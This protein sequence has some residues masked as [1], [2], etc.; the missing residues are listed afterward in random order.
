MDEI[1]QEAHLHFKNL[2]TE[3]KEIPPRQ[4]HYPLSAVP[5]LVNEEDNRMMTAPITSEEISKAIH[6]M[7]PDKAPGPD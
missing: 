1:K 7:N 6:G 5:K 2:Y 3:E 4:D